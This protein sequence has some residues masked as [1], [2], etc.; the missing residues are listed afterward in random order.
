MAAQWAESRGVDVD[1]YPADWDNIDR[2]GAVVKRNT[3]GKLY[4]ALAGHVRNERMLREGRP[5]SAVGFRAEKE[6]AICGSD[7]LSMGLR[8]FD[9]DG[10]LFPGCSGLVL[11]TPKLA[12]DRLESLAAG[13]ILDG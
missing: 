8:Q 4:D 2:L 9:P 11:R 5:D 1:P 10:L 12:R 13:V 6:P 3:R 7:A